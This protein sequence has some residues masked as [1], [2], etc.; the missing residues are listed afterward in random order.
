MKERDTII[1][2]VRI[3][4]SLFVRV[5]LKVKSKKVSRNSWV[6]QAIEERLRSHKKKEVS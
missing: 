1:L 5:E 3:K 4:K 6:N 2:P